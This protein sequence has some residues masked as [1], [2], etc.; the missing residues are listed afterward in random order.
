MAPSGR[1]KAAG[2]SISGL[3]IAGEGSLASFGV[4]WST[5][6]SASTSAASGSLNVA[7]PSG[8]GGFGGS[9]L[10]GGRAS[11]STPCSSSVGNES[12]TVDTGGIAFKSPLSANASKGGNGGTSPTAS[13]GIC[14]SP[15]VVAA[16]S[17]TAVPRSVTALGTATSS[18]AGPSPA[19]AAVGGNEATDSASASPTQS[20]IEAAA[21]TPRTPSGSSEASRS[22]EDGAV[23]I[24]PSPK[25]FAKML[26]ASTSPNTPSSTISWTVRCPSTSRSTE[27]TSSGISPMRW[28]RT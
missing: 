6:K 19:N 10:I 20:G 28:A 17:S 1:G 15:G 24:M 22:A 5:A 3:M 11:A 16:P 25:S 21:G 8:V 26:K 12:S 4:G 27:F 23:W 9:V 18:G 14:A 7:P 2:I 13:G